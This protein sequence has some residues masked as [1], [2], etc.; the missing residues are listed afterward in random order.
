MIRPPGFAGAV[1]G[2]AEWGDLRADH[3]ARSAVSAELGISPHWAYLDQVHSAS[4]LIASHSGNLGEGDALV[5]TTPDLPIMVATADCVPVVLEAA[6]ASAVVHAGWKGAAAGILPAALR[7]M[8]ELGHR[9]IRAAIG[10]AIGPCCYEV[11]EEVAIRFPGNEATT[12][13]GKRSVDIP[14][15]LASQLAGVDIWRSAECTFCSERLNSWRRDQTKERQVTV[16]W[17]P[18]S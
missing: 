7:T 17:L 2:T 5:V 13:W 6:K 16:A 3:E 4:V 10:P 18:I 8:S 12:T 15:F 1:F 11:G 9:T 14:G